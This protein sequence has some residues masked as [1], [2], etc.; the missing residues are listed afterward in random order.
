MKIVRFKKLKYVP[1]S[2]EDPKKPSVLKKVLLTNQ[3]L[4]AGKIQMINWAKLPVEKTFAAHY[5]QDMQEIFIIITG[6]AKMITDDEEIIVEKGDTVVVPVGAIHA[7]TN[8]G[9]VD[10]EYLAIGVSWQKG[11]QTVVV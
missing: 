5:H 10:V 3:D 8:L 2:H 1:A 7:M 4:I 9:K 6:R 11:G